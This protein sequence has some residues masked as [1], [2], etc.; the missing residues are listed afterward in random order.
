MK[1]WLLDHWGSP[2]VRVLQ[3]THGGSSGQTWRGDHPCRLRTVPVRQLYLSLFYMKPYLKDME[4]LKEVRLWPKAVPPRQLAMGAR[5]AQGSMGSPAPPF[6]L[7]PSL[8]SVHSSMCPPS[9]CHAPPSVCPPVR[10]SLHSSWSSCPVPRASAAGGAGPAA[11]PCGF[12]L[13]SSPSKASFLRPGPKYGQVAA[14]R[15]ALP[16][17]AVWLCRG[18]HALA[19]CML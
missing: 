4:R 1:S 5:L 19:G 16:G 17:W 18:T 3:G 14:S 9:A 11:W 13:L 7:H 6:L 12:R 8:L 15:G 10:R 2:Q